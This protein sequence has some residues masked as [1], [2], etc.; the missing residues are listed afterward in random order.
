MEGNQLYI[1]QALTNMSQQYR[2]EDDT[3]IASIIAPELLVE[4]KTGLYLYY[5]QQ[6]R[7]VANS[8]RTGNAKT[9][10]TST[11]WTWKNYDTLHEHAI[12]EGIQKD[13]FDMFQNPL[14]PM[15]DATMT[16]MDNMTI[17]YEQAVANLLTDTSKVTQYSSPSV[18]WNA[19]TGAGSPIIDISTAVSTMLINGLRRPNTIVVGWQAW[20]Q[21]MNHPDFMDRIKFS[22][23]GTLTEDLFARIISE[24]SGT[25][26][27]RVL[28]GTAIADT[29]AEQ[30]PHPGTT[31]NGPIW[32]KHVWLMYCTPTPGLRQVNGLY[33]LRLKNGRYVDGW[34]NLDRKTTYV[35]V[36]DYYTP[37]LVGPT[38]VY[39]LQN[40]VA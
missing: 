22:Q 16:C 21:L 14:D 19:S 39:F 27:T 32:G 26:I 40:V 12:K 9:A 28:I 15:M 4:K 38:A 8:L 31:T 6:L 7:S 3:Y 25:K 11:N 24:S 18:Q 34:A 17:E 35:R 29:S 30:I 1:P 33:T 37:F 36:N 13:V 5:P 10:E 23:L 2:N 20:L